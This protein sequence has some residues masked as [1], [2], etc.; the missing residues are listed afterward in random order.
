VQADIDFVEEIWHER[1]QLS[2]K[3][4]FELELEY[5]GETRES[6]CAWLAEEIKKAGCDYH[7]LSTLDDINWLL[8]IRGDDV[9]HVPVMLSYL[10]MK[11]EHVVLYAMDEAVAPV[12]ASL[13]ESGIEI[14][15]YDSFYTDLAT[16]PVDATV[17]LDKKRCN[18]RIISEIAGEIIDCDNPCI[19][20]K[21]IKNPTELKNIKQAHVKDGVAVTKFICW[22]KQEIGKSGVVITEATAADKLEEFRRE[23]GILDISFD[24]ISAYNENA[25]MMHYHASH[26]TAAI[27]KPQGFLLVDSG[28][29][30]REGTTDV[31]RTI[32]LG[33]IPQEWKLH[34][35]TVCKSMFGLANAKFLYGCSGL[36]LDILSRGPLWKLGIDYR[37]GTGHGVGYLLNI[38]ESPNGFRYKVVPERKDGCLLEEGMVTTDEPGVY[39]EGSHGIRIENEL[40]CKKG[41]KNEYGQFMEFE[42]ITYVPI[43]LDAID[44]A[45]LTD[46]EI[47]YINSYH[48]LVYDKVAPYL[49]EEEKEWLKTATRNLTR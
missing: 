10:I 26:E 14:R 3:P 19:L 27:L 41:L 47:E 38:H 6:K 42:A 7:V 35:T 23:Q 32:V 44:C 9:T 28:G 37:C 4:A 2:R 21:A 24:T 43:D 16:I 18:Y 15:P 25:A 11:K 1:P 31:T 5:C 36:S 22:L 20:R 8:N 30:Y 33:D 40:V 45:Y 48:Q 29:H 39:I 46:E 12:R 49:S 17:L 13:E 34:Y